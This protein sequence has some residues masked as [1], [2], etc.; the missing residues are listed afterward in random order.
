MKTFMKF[1]IKPIKVLLWLAGILIFLLLS[2]AL[3]LPLWVKPVVCNIANTVVPDLVKSDFKLK[4]FGLNYFTGELKVGDLELSN[5]DGYEPREAVKLGHFSAKVD[6]STIF[7]EVIHIEYLDLHDLF[8]SYVNKD[9]LSNF[10]AL[11]GKQPEPKSELEI[12]R[13]PTRVPQL[14]LGN[15]KLDDLEKLGKIEVPDFDLSFG[16]SE[17]PEKKFIIDKIR[18]SGITL[19]Y[20]MFPIPL[21]PVTLT[22]IGTSKGGVSLSEA[23]QEIWDSLM[24]VA[25]NTGAL[26]KQY[27]DAALQE[28]K[29]Q[30][31]AERARAEEQLNAARAEVEAQLKAVQE[32]AA[33]EIEAAKAE[34]KA[35]IESM[36]AA[37]LEAGIKSLD[38]GSKVLDS[39]VDLGKGIGEGT[40]DIGKGLGEDA[41]RLGKGAEKLGKDLIKM[42]K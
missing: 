39:T 15:L 42:L 37:A 10:D 8:V 31:E 3:T 20:E 1:I 36:K 11:M 29:A 21:P 33:A 4:D 30:L 14:K 28:A 17:A 27:G 19:Q 5:P 26:F 25:F 13:L 23:G 38:S 35:Q 24:S 6:M 9:G 16:K 18:V 7:S 12:P 41:K 2:L 34:A 22:D 32:D 40:I